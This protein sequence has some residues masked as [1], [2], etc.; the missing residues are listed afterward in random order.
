MEILLELGVGGSAM[1]ETP[2]AWADSVGGSCLAPSDLQP[3]QP[4]APKGPLRGLAQEECHTVL[5]IVG[6]AK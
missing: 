1:A 2:P 3:W 5:R 4:E 6:L